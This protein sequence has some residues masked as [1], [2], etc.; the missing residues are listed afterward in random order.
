[1]EKGIPAVIVTK[2]QNWIAQCLENE[3]LRLKDTAFVRERK[4]NAKLLLFLILHRVYTSLQLDLDDFYDGI[5]YDHVTKQAFSKARQQLNPE[6]VRHFFDITAEEAAKDKATPSY[7]GMRLI[8]IDGS[9][10]AL[11]N[12]PELKQVFGCSGSKKDAAT[13]LC[14]TAYGPLDHV[15]YDC[16]IDSYTKDERDLARLHVKRLLELGLKGSLLLF[17]RWY[18]SAEFIA[19]L[20]KNGFP[21][22]MRARS[23]WNLEADKVKTQDWITLEHEEKHFSVRVLKVKL[24][25]G[26][27]ETLLTSLNQKQLPIGK[28]AG[29]YFKRW[30]VEIS[31]DL[32]KS[33][34]QLENFSGKTVVSVKQ[35]FYATMYLA[36]LA[37]F[38]AAE[39]DVKIAEVDA[40]KNLK[41]L[42]QS[43][44]NR[45]IHVLRKAFIR[46]LLEPDAAIR[47][48][49]L[50][51][52]V[53]TIAQKPVPIVPNRSPKRGIPRKK[54]F[55]IAKKSVI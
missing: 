41:Y 44:R 20:R 4:L 22:V 48:A 39:S 38:I 11:E 30:A 10:I 21:F 36:N 17:D 34:L 29:L 52:I 37:T 54:R 35:D 18:P 24:P 3:G 8:A 14:S 27:T 25:N 5:G 28:A 51:R 50:Q 26:E 1:M 53:D 47:D 33:K 31:Y 45:T 55:P 46:L 23:K 2:T 16:R 9:D 19:F 43:N 49:M 13:A 15:I 32:I 42:R 40:P 6:F 7:E 12:A